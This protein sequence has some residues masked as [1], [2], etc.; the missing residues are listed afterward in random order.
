M[1]ISVFACLSVCISVYG[2]VCVC[3]YVDL[4]VCKLRSL[5]PALTFRLFTDSESVHSHSLLL[6]SIKLQMDHK[7]WPPE[8]LIQK[9]SP[10]VDP[11]ALAQ[12]A[13]KVLA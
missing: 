10:T 7:P 1:S 12:L 3:L 4:S 5:P 6:F 9:T 2:P 11:A 13:T 8:S